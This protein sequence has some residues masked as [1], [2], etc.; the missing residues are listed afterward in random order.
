MPKKAT[1][2]TSYTLTNST[3]KKHYAIKLYVFQL[4][5]QYI[6]QWKKALS[7]TLNI[8]LTYYVLFGII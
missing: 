7:I 3:I 8:D 1:F 6:P 4:Y 5:V 2:N